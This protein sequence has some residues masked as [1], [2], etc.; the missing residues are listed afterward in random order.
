MQTRRRSICFAAMVLTFALP[1]GS[2]A[3]GG[4][5]PAT[6]QQQNAVANGRIAFATEG[7][8]SQIYTVNPD[9]SDERQLTHVSGGV[10]VD[11]PDWSPTA[12]GSPTSATLLA[13][14]TSG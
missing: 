2:S 6:R 12:L 8:H 4:A 1:L 13:P 9:G 14:P 3:Y 10:Q 7:G 11:M 5:P